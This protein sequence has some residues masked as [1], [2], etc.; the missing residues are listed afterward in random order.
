MKLRFSVSPQALLERGAEITA[1]IVGEFPD[2]RIFM[3]EQEGILYVILPN[4]MD[5]VAVTQAVCR[6]LARIGIAA[7]PKRS[8]PLF[9]P[10]CM[11]QRPRRRT[12]SLP[13]FVTSLI[14]VALIIGVLAVFLS[15]AVSPSLTGVGFEVTESTLGTGKQEGEDYAGKI[16]LIDRIFEQ[17]ALYDTNGEL[18]LEEMLQ[19]YVSATGDKY[20]RYYTEVEYKAM[21]AE[22][23]ATMVG[24]GI[25]ATEDA[26][27]HDICIVSVIPDSPAQKAGLVPGDRIVAIGNGEERVSVVE[28]GYKAAI[29]RL[30]GDEGTTAEFTVARDGVEIPFAVVRAVVTT[31]SV[32]GKIS[33]TNA[34]VGCVSITQFNMSTPTQLKAVMSELIEGGCEKFVFDVRNN[35]GGDMKSIVAV[36]SYFLNKDDTIVSTVKKDGDTTYHKVAVVSYTGDYAGCSVKAEE[37]GMYRG[38]EIVVLSN[39]RTASAAELFTAVLKDYGLATV[40]GE[41]TRG[42]GVLQHIY[43][44]ESWGY[45]GAVKLTVGYYSPPSGINYDGIGIAPDVEVAPDPEVATI[46]PTLLTE[47]QD[48]QLL[49]AIGHLTK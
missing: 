38:Y 39:G 34:L 32:K 10:V 47:A 13:V 37:I 23:N 1:L 42:K 45:T 43:H 18:L 3:D 22:A 46:H 4:S 19:A 5:C 30:R 16:A 8:A 27:H 21:V 41:N 48:A 31:I 11:E 15:G 2:S 28:I 33:D 6:M 26:E 24:V 14:A 35:P 29:E 44:L 20:A 9:P 36:L 49:A 40:I 7:E 12:V 17:Y 25:T